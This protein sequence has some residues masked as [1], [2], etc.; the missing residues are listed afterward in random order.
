V[1]IEPTDLVSFDWGLLHDAVLVSIAVNWE[2]GTADLLMDLPAP[3]S[4]TYEDS[5]RNAEW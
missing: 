5:H 1:T 2:P 4:A 3:A